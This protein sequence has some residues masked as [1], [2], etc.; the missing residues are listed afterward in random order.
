M[1]EGC[2]KNVSYD[3]LI[4]TSEPSIDG[5]IVLNGYR[6]TRIICEGVHRIHMSYASFRE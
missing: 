5:R 2:A 6:K 3:T 4:K 1:D